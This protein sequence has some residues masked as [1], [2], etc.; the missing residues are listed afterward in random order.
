MWRRPCSSWSTY[1]NRVQ[2]NQLAMRWRVSGRE[3]V[4][5]WLRA[6]PMPVGPTTTIPTTPT[7]QSTGTTQPH[8]QQRPL[9]T[10]QLS[11][12]VPTSQLSRE[13]DQPQ[14]EVTALPATSQVEGHRPNLRHPSKPNPVKPAGTG[15]RPICRI[16]PRAPCF[17]RESL[18]Q[19]ALM[20]LRSTDLESC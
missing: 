9:S 20:N 13:V 5:R 8:L 10:S 11:R 2:S 3:Q 12:E 19:H 6:S 15:S 16:T 14:Q 18:P 4:G 7:P 1:P 17:A